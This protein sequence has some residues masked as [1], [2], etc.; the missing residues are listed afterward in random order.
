MLRIYL[1]CKR[2]TFVKAEYNTLAD[3]NS[4]LQHNQGMEQ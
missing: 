2:A 3:F 4:W 1:E